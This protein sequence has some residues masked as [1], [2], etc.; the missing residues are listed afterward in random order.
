MGSSGTPTVCKDTLVNAY[1]AK[2]VAWIAAGV[3]G[4]RAELSLAS[5]TAIIA[6]VGTDLTA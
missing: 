5:Y 2:A 3:A 1:Y 6:K 4:K